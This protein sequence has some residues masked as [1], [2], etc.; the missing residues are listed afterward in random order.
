[1]LISACL[2]VRDEERLLARC[3]RR[4]RG[5]YDELCVVD[6]G[7]TDRTA[8]VAR[9]LGA[10]VERTTEC[11]GPDGKILD[12]SAA[13]NAALAM[14]RGEWVL[15][16]DADEV[17]EPGGAARIRRAVRRTDAPGLRVTLRDGAI[18]W[19]ATRLFRNDPRHRYV[20]RVHEG[21]R[22]PPGSPP[23]RDAPGVVFRH[24]P[25][26]RDKEGSNERNLRL[27]EAEVRDAPGSARALFYLANELRLAGRYDEAV[28]RYEQQ[29][30]LGGGW[31][32]ERYRAA[33]CVATCR[34]AQGR[35]GE[36]IDAGLRALRLD[37]RYA[38][39]HC[40]VG[41]AYFALGEYEF[42]RQWYKSALAC[43]APPADSPM[44]VMAVAYDRYPRAKIRA[45]ERRLRERRA[46]RREGGP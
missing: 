39:T 17:V 30:A 32:T 34:F 16:I 38:E 42:A 6:T 19:R 9:R 23:V 21:V 12:F 43:G 26:K 4:L 5:A 22:F 35:H 41:D 14:A 33:H 24:L 18:T 25:D 13:R 27:C 7:S 46:A 45:C 1:M 29:L 2:I 20:G 3:V 10:A 8:E 36:A 11:N 40:V 31:P 15:S 28:A 44:F 37:P